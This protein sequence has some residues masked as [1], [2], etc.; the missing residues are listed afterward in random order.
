MDDRDLNKLSMAATDE[1]E[2]DEEEMDNEKEEND[3]DEE[4]GEGQQGGSQAGGRNEREYHTGAAQAGQPQGTQ[5]QQGLAGGSGGSG[6]GGGSQ[7]QRNQIPQPIPLIPHEDHVKVLVKE[8]QADEANK[9][10]ANRLQVQQVNQTQQAITK[11]M[12]DAQ[13]MPIPYPEMDFSPNDKIRAAGMK[14]QQA[15]SD[16]SAKKKALEATKKARAER[17]KIREKAARGGVAVE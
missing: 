2:P 14:A 7:S 9:F 16:P 12:Q 15:L 5:P 17:D 4:E 11:A 3:E 10:A 1:P 13:V 8:A 6:G